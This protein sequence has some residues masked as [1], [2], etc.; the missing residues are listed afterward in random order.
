M[1]I[2]VHTPER[3]CYTTTAFIGRKEALNSL[4]VA[5]AV[6]DAWEQ[7]GLPRDRVGVVMVDNVGYCAKAFKDH[8]AVFFGNARL[9]TCW[10]HSQRRQRYIDFIGES[11]LDYTDTH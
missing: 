11:L 10:A 9:R 8:V 1:N 5:K 3:V 4:T 6:M 7:L 2:I